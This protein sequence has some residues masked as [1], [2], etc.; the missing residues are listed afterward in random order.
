MGYKRIINGKSYNTETSTLVHSVSARNDMVFDGL[1]QT[2]HGAFFLY[3]Y[4]EDREAGGI[5]PMSDDDAQRWLE[6]HDAD[7]V[8]IERYFGTFPEAG[9]A[10]SRITLRLPGNLY[11]RV[12]A[13]AAA[14]NL[15]MNTY[16]M[17]LL[18]R[19]ETRT[20]AGG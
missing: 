12:A 15:S 11:N 20:A 18:E 1:Y 17:R 3:W 7:A 5:K 4:D 10:E 8:I 13:S 19:S 2:K 9:A 16:L 6:K 14:A